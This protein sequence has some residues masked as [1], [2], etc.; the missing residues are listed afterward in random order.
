MQNLIA[1]TKIC[2][3]ASHDICSNTWILNNETY[4]AFPFDDNNW[5]TYRYMYLKLIELMY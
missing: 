4:A 1:D 5:I 3:P 2:L